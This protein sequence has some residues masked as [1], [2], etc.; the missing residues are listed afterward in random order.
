MYKLFSIIALQT[1]VSTIPAGAT[2][3]GP[4]RNVPMDW[5]RMTDMYLR[6]MV[7]RPHVEAGPGFFKSDPVEYSPDQLSK[8]YKKL[9]A[10]KKKMEEENKPLNP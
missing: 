6:R 1:I 7:N 4:G 2:V 3:S 10:L 8:E 9:F 5:L